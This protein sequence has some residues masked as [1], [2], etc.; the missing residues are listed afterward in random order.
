[1][2]AFAHDGSRYAFTNGA[3]ESTP[4][5]SV[6]RESTKTRVTLDRLNRGNVASD[7]QRNYEPF[8]LPVSAGG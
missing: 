7:A 5:G 2:P 6:S 1:L 4:F 8:A 3:G